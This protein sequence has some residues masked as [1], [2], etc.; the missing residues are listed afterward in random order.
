MAENMDSIRVEVAFATPEKQRIVAVDVPL[1][2]TA[3]EA[4]RLSGIAQ[5]F[6]QDNLAVA[7]LG[8]FGRKLTEPQTTQLSAGD[9]VE[10]YRPLLIDPKQARLNRAAKAR[11]LKPD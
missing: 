5:E 6:P 2:T 3:T 7:P 4:V 10:I 1:G 11:Q 9:R 8:I